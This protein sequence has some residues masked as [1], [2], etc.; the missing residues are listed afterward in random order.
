[1]ENNFENM[2]IRKISLKDKL[3]IKNSIKHLSQNEFVEIFKLIK[4]SQD[5]YTENYNGIFINLSKLSN[6]TLNK[7]YNLVNYCI[8]NKQILEKENVER[9]SIKNLVKINETYNLPAEEISKV[10]DNN[11]EEI[12]NEKVNFIEKEIMSYSHSIQVTPQNNYQKY[13]GIR[14]KLVKK[15]KEKSNSNEL[16]I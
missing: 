14:A 10:S 1:M 13:K 7:I 2:D 16:T 12:I 8:T 4:D 15:C 9:N 3:F 11:K 5:K 6:F